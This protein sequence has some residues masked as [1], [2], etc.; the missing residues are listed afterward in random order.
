MSWPV[1][2]PRCW[3][4]KK[5]TLSPRAKA[6]SNV[7]WALLEVQT[8]PSRLPTNALRLAALFM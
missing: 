3:S 8:M 6:Y 7:R 4:G 2:R 1:L 5:S